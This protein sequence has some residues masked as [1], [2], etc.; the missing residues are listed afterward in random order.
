[1]ETE[2]AKSLKWHNRYEHAKNGVTNP[3]TEAEETYQSEQALGSSA[4]MNSG[5]STNTWFR[6][7]AKITFILGSGIAVGFTIATKTKIVG[8]ESM[9]LL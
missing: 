8:E 1:L 9:S 6:T 3:F 4:G 5:D 2:Q 7:M